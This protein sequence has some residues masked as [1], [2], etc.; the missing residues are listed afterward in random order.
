MAAAVPFT[1]W[2]AVVGVGLGYW[3]LG[4]YRH[5]KR[6]PDTGDVIAFGRLLVVPLT[7]GM[8]LAAALTM[9]SQETHPQLRGEVARL[10]RR[11]R[12]D[13]M[14]AALAG[15]DGLLGELFRRVA[16]AHSSGTSPVR[17]V[18]THVESLHSQVRMESL[19]RIRSLPVTLSVPLTL[20]IVPGFL[21]VLVGP[22]VVSR[23]AEM[24]GGLIGT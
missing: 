2:W 4:R 12:Q 24:L 8:S 20:L 7:G 17:S 23:L 18:L 6:P 22:S 3:S 11:S 1:W 10:L 19:S 21:L 14:A 15:S 13:G 16:G 5:R 9:A